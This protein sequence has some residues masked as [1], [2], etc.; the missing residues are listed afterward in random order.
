MAGKREG[1]ESA[2]LLKDEER[3]VSR[4]E[5]RPSN[6]T[7]HSGMMAEKSPLGLAVWRSLGRWS[8]TKSTVCCMYVN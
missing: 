8:V 7:I 4:R 6:A 5:H 1:W 3:E 2:M